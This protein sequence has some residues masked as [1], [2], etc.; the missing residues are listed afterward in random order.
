MKEFPFIFYQTSDFYL[1]DNQPIVV[2]PS[3]MRML[4]SLSL[5]EII[6]PKYVK[7][8]TNFRALSFEDYIVTSRLIHMNLLLSNF[9]KRS[10]VLAT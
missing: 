10:M 9:T 5:D 8:L 7:I 2:H 1:V 6:L 3:S 4:T